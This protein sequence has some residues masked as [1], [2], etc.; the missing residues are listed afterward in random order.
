MTLRIDPPQIDGE[1]I[2]NGDYYAMGDAILSLQATLQQVT[3]AITQRQGRWRDATFVGGNFTGIGG[4]TWTVPA[5]NRWKYLVLDQ[6]LFLDLEV[7]G[8]TIAGVVN[9]LRVALP[10]GFKAAGTVGSRAGVAVWNGTAGAAAAAGVAMAAAA[11]ALGYLSIKRWDGTANANWP[12]Y[13]DLMV[14]LTMAVEISPTNLG[15]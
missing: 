10:A 8:T 4:G 7:E 12:T 9:E 15:L 2:R 3:A 11:G 6:L 5:A 1:R 14:G 13:T